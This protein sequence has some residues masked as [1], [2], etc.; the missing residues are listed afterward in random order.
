MATATKTKANK[1][2]LIL[3]ERKVTSDF[4]LDGEEVSN[5]FCVEKLEDAQKLK[6][7]AFY[8]GYQIVYTNNNIVFLKNNLIYACY[9]TYLDI[10]LNFER[11]LN[12]DNAEIPKGFIY[13]FNNKYYCIGNADENSNSLV[14]GGLVQN[15]LSFT[16]LSRFTNCKPK[17]IPNLIMTDKIKIVDFTKDS[18]IQTKNKKSP[19]MGYTLTDEKPYVWHRPATFLFNFVDRKYQVIMGQDE[20][21]YFACEL[22]KDSNCKTINEAFV[23]LIPEEIRNKKG[24]L[25]QGEWF[26]VPVSESRLP[27]FEDYLCEFSHLSLPRD[28][29]YSDYHVI[30]GLG[31]VN[32]NNKIYATNFNL[33]HEGHKTLTCEKWVCFYKNTAVR[34]FSEKGVD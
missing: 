34:S 20:G 5:Y 17:N 2:V 13:K 18:I 21:S 14:E 30:D 27:K 31:F 26:L 23:S 29:D 4:Y 16:C 33:K 32:K 1:N 6:K 7:K 24:V 28:N 22:P 10:N 8:K 19:G 25:R 12:I 15:A 11:Y 3:D 9:D